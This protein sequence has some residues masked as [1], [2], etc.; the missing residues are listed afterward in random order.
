MSKHDIDDHSGVETTGHEWDGIKELNNPLPK[1]WLYILYATIIW[2]IGYWIAFPAWP[3]INSYTHGLLNNSDRGRVATEVA[4]LEN[5]RAPMFAKIQSMPI[6]QVKNDEELFRFAQEAGKST[7]N[8]NCAT[9]HGAGGQGNKGFPSLVDDVWL[10]DGTYEGIRQ[11][12]NFGIRSGHDQ[13]RI[14]AMPAF[15]RDGMLDAGQVGDVTEYVMSLSKMS[16]ANAGKAAR[17]AAVYAAN[18]VVCHGATGGG[19]VTQGAPNLTDAEWL[20]GGTRE[21]IAAQ[22]HN[23]RGGV[24]PAWSAKLDAETVAALTVYVHSLGGGK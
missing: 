5:G 15:G 21:D 24:M 13:A 8:D 22:I 6:D 12:I 7:F 4:A 3:T 10:W 17:G 16:G 9:C 19:D 18:C 11:S 1:W 2:S 20:Y 14:S 23:G